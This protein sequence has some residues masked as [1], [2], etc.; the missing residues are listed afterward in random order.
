[1]EKQT[2]NQEM[3]SFPILDIRKL[4]KQSVKN[5]ASDDLFFFMKT[6][7]DELYKRRIR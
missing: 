6:C 5:M 4:F 3:E 7:M 1:M 2:T